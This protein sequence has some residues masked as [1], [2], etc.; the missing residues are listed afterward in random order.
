MAEGEPSVELRTR[1]G[2]ALLGPDIGERTVVRSFEAAS[3]GSAAEVETVSVINPVGKSCFQLFSEG[4]LPC[5]SEG[6]QS[7]DDWMNLLT[8]E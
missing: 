7:A 6:Q 4:F 2:I 8:A 5:R 3:R 1:Q